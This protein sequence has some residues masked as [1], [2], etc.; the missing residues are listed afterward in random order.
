MNTAEVI[1]LAREFGLFALLIVAIFTD[2]AYGKIYNWLVYPAVVAG[3][4]LAVAG[5]YVGP[6]SA[7]MIDSPSVIESLLGLALAAGLFGF[8][9]FRGWMGAADVKLAAAIGALKGLQFFIWALIFITLAGFML[10]VVMLIWQG[11]F[12]ESVKNSLVFFFRPKKLKKKME[13]SG[14]QPVLI[15]YG[16]AMAIGTMCAWFLDRSIAGY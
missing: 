2:I 7:S 16:V 9:F 14:R 8:F 6:A 13:E 11:R 4:G 5:H 3:V 1:T 15:P 10:A 12:V